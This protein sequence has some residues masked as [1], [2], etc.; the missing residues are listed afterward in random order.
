MP[1]I[2]GL[3]LAVIVAIFAHF[4]RFDRSR[5]FY[6]VV[7]MVIASYYV[8]FAAMAASRSGLLTETLIFAAF[9]I[10]AV[11]GFRTSLWIV[12]AGL[13]L[14]AIFDFFRHSLLPGHG[15]PQW[16][17]GFCLMYDVS[18]GAGLALLLPLDRRRANSH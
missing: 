7:L 2:V 1:E 12:V 11:L 14:H 5:A 4:V 18:A 17:P 16:W 3:A 13:L 6:P 15:I 9:G 8:L 10:V